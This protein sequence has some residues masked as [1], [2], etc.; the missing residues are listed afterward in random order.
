[1]KMA[2]IKNQAGKKDVRKA[3][4]APK[5][6]NQLTEAERIE[7]GTRPIFATTPNFSKSPEERAA[8]KK[9]H[10]GKKGPTSQIPRPK[11]NEVEHLLSVQLK[12][13]DKSVEFKSTY[14]YHAKPSEVKSILFTFFQIGNRSVDDTHKPQ[15][16]KC[17]YNGRLFHID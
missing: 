7:E 13:K 15:I 10:T 5:P 6:Y 12:N 4:P 2:N 8:L 14:T 17:Y 16:A 1:M 3:K 9:V 11:R